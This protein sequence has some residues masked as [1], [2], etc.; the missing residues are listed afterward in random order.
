LS[1]FVVGLSLLDEIS[2]EELLGQEN[3]MCLSANRAESFLLAKLLKASCGRLLVKLVKAS[4]VRLLYIRVR[5]LP[6]RIVNFNI[7]GEFKIGGGSKSM[8]IE[9]IERLGDGVSFCK[10][11]VMTSSIG[12][13]MVL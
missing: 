11:M 3:K 5:V 7:F 9:G 8:I 12:L 2:I 6:M 10:R 13:R 4:V 1:E